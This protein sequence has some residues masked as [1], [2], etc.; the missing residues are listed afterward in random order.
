MTS[1]SILHRYASAFA[2]VVTAPA[3]FFAP[4]DAMYQLRSFDDI[5]RSSPDLAIALESPAIPI[6]RKRAVIQ[7]FVDLLKL[8]RV[9]RNFLFVLCDHR[10]LGSLHELIEALDIEFDDR[11]GFIRAEVSAASQLDPS[12]LDALTHK[13]ARVTGK[14]IRLNF[15]V[16]PSLMGGVVARVGA[17]VY[18][19]SVRGRLDGLSKQLSVY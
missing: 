9:V 16:D 5:V 4:Q 7:R 3:S 17:K 15:Q 2:D 18:D 14:Q 19:G 1:S 10:R 6:G 11:L 12:Q 13:L 8:S